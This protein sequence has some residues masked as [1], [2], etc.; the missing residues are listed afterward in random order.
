MSRYILTWDDVHDDCLTLCHRITR[1]PVDLI[2]AVSRGGLVPAAII[3]YEMGL[4]V[5]FAIDPRRPA[6]HR[7]DAHDLLIVD[8]V[9]DTGTTF[10]ALREFFPNAYFVAP[11]AKPL[12][13]AAC[14]E[15]VLEVVQDTWIVMPWAPRD[16]AR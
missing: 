10:R 1:R 12:G 6:L 3:S 4:P 15:W 9:C 14:D 5:S 16:V 7:T 13:V 11:Y 2:A 8:D